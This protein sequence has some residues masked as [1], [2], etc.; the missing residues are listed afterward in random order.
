[1]LCLLG[2]DADPWSLG[3][4]D[5]Y[6]FTIVVTNGPRWEGPVAKSYWLLNEG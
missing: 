2:A 3:V 1:M 6:M 4:M 5:S